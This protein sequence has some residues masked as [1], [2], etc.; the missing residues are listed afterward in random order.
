MY[1]QHFICICLYTGG[2]DA[3]YASHPQLCASVSPLNA[4][5]PTRVTLDTCSIQAYRNQT[6]QGT[7][8]E[9]LPFLYLGSAKDS[10][11]LR[12][13]KKMEITAVLNI[14]TTCPNHFESEFEYMSILVDDSYQ[15]DLLSR[16]NAAIQFIGKYDIIWINCNELHFFLFSQ[17]KRLKKAME[18]C[19]FTVM[20]AFLDLQLF[21]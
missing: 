4:V 14:T 9:I 10:S 21:A 8:V 1:W 13:M 19:L 7:P 20:L 16:L 15:T 17:Q 3:F 6:P 11:D 12:I 5:S 18:K 2:L